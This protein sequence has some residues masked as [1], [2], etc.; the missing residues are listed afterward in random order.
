MKQ[1]KK[2]NK[3]TTKQY[4]GRRSD[5]GAEGYLSMMA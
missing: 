3:Q 4:R 5:I 1:K 2:N